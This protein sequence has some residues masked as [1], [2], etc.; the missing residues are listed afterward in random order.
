MLWYIVYFQTV[1]D[2]M[3]GTLP[4]NYYNMLLETGRDSGSGCQE[5]W[6][7]DPVSRTLVNRGYNWKM[8]IRMDIPNDDVKVLYG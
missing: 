1:L 2:Q 4:L 3:G 5:V 6:S 7:Q 8:V